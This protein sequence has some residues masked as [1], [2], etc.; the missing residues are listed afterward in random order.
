MYTKYIEYY[1]NVVEKQFPLLL[2]VSDDGHGISREDLSL[3]GDRYATSK[4]RELQ[5]LQ[6]TC[7]FGFHGVFWWYLSTSIR[8]EIDH[9]LTEIFQMYSYNG[10]RPLSSNMYNGN[11]WLRP[12]YNRQIGS[13]VLIPPTQNPP[14]ML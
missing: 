8:S 3:V 1:T 7:F 5:D 2:Q 11:I 13:F 12:A 9:I 10:E 14:K 6:H 4:C